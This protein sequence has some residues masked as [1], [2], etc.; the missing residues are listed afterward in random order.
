MKREEK[1][2]TEMA[3]S[4]RTKMDHLRQIKGIIKPLALKAT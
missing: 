4:I 1:F 2:V 3:M